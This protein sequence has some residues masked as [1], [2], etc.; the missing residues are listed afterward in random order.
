MQGYVDSELVSESALLDLFLLAECDVLI[1]AFHSQVCVVC[2]GGSVCVCV[3][4]CVCL[5]VCV[6]H[7]PVIASDAIAGGL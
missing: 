7:V 1:G 2:V 6:T 5:C 3:F 4:V